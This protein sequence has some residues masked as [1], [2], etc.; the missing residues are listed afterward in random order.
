MVRLIRTQ[1]VIGVIRSVIRLAAVEQILI[2]FVF[3]NGNP[4]ESI[5]KRYGGVEIDGTRRKMCRMESRNS[6]AQPMDNTK[7]IINSH[8]KDR[9]Y[10]RFRI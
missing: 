5:G 2:I 9:N 7:K 10:E 6:V 1:S 3:A 8:K 4:V